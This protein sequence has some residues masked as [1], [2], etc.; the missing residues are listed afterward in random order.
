MSSFYFLS[1]IGDQSILAWSCIGGGNHR[2]LHGYIMKTGL[3]FFIL[4]GN[5]ARSSPV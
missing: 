2:A 3:S 5:Q 1:V 4:S